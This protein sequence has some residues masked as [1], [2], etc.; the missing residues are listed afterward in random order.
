MS[1]LYH[2]VASPLFKLSLQR[3][4]AFLT[5]AFGEPLATATLTAIKQQISQQL[6]AQ[7]ELA[8][9]SERLL[10]LG[11]PDYRQWQLDKHNLLFYRVNEAEQRIELLLVMDSRQSLRKLLFELN[12]L[13]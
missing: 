2:I 9:I 12:L 11:I 1:N 4:K 10:A 6:P 8:P 13:F 5:T 7:P 3:L